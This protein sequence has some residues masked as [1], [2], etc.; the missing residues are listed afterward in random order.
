MENNSKQNDPT[1]TSVDAT[2]TPL[3]DQVLQQPEREAPL[4]VVEEADMSEQLSAMRMEANQ[5]AES[6][7]LFAEGATSMVRKMPTVLEEQMM[8]Q[9]QKNPIKVLV[10]TVALSF[11]VTLS[12]LGRRAR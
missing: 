3:V 12:L 5:I 2:D 4:T 10:A 8:R 9:I 11:G 7:K 1:S 6:I